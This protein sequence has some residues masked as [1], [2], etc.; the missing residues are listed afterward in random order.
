VIFYEGWDI[1]KWA[2]VLSLDAD[3]CAG[4]Q[5]SLAGEWRSFC[6]LELSASAVG[7][8]ML[9]PNVAMTCQYVMLIL[10]FLQ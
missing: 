6:G 5:V 10:I 4:R 3:A 7:S 8:C 9:G 1:I 2:H